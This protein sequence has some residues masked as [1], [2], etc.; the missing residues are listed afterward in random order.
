MP[1][2]YQELKDRLF[3]LQQY[4]FNQSWTFNDYRLETDDMEFISFY[5]EGAKI[6]ISKNPSETE[7]QALNKWRKQ[8][9]LQ[10]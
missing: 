7:L 3:N 1:Q 4:L 10:I 2:N 5:H 9:M 6:T 8:S